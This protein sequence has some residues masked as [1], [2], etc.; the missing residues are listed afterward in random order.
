MSGK[1][2]MVCV[3]CPNGCR[4]S[5][6]TEIRAGTPHVSVV[7]ALCKRGTE[8]ARDECVAPKRAVTTSVFDAGRRAPLSVKTAA[9]VPKEKIFDVLSAVH[10]VRVSPPVR[11]GDTILENVCET[12]VDVLATGIAE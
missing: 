6:V 11:I 8:Y 2:E 7:G 1:R 9:P 4:L 12:G 3:V 10:T 5:V